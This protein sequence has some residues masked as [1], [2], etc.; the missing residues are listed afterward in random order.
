MP[1]RLVNVLADSGLDLNWK[2]GNPELMKCLLERQSGA[3]V[4][5]V[6]MLRGVKF[7]PVAHLQIVKRYTMAASKR[8]MRV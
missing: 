8:T 7:S 6:G 5:V 1:D 4:M 3:A 2:P